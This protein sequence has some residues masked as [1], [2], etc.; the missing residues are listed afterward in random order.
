MSGDGNKPPR[1]RVA[2]REKFDV[3][4]TA[5]VLAALHDAVDDYNEA[6]ARGVPPRGVAIVFLDE[7][8]DKSFAVAW[9]VEG[10]SRL[11]TMGLLSAAHIDMNNDDRG[12]FRGGA[13]PGEA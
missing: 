6:L 13:P 1:L 2:P 10:M 3:P 4:D 7:K 9:R 11:E 12:D 8:P 5:R